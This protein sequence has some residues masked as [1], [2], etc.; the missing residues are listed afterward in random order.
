[1]NNLYS[2]TIEDYLE[3]CERAKKAG[4]SPGADMTLIFEAYMAE[5]GQKPMGHTEL[6]MKELAQEYASYEKKVLKIDTDDK[7]N[8]SFELHK[9]KEENT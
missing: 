1:M 5:K 9:P 4:L 6:S 2:I 7:G 8:Q 3:V